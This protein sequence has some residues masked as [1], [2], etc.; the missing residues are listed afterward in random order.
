MKLDKDRVFF[1]ADTHFSSQRHLDLCCRPFE[2]IQ[3]MDEQMVNNWNDVV[4]LYGTVLH[5]GDFGNPDFINQLNGE[6]ILIPGNYDYENGILKKC[7]RGLLHDEYFSFDK[8][9]NLLTIDNQKI[10][11]MHEPLKATNDYFYLFGHIHGTQRVKKNG[12]NVG[13]D[14]HNYAPISFE[15]V[16]FYKKAISNHFDENVFCGNN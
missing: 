16:M 8:V 2:D 14:C 6:I 7:Y 10:Q 1:T 12:L 15:R 13:V 9:S 5:L 4:P 3:D 11:L